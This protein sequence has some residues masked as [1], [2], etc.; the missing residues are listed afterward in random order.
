M[1]E[2]NK[3]HNN[4]NDKIIFL[5]NASIHHSK[6]FK[7]YVKET[8]MHVLYNVPYDKNPVEYVFSLLRKVLERSEFTT[9]N[10]LTKIVNNFKNNL[11]S[12]KLNNIFRH[13]FNLF[14]LN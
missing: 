8:K 3:I 4:E 12:N 2:F 10:E 5:D 6:D 14:N 9:I 11:I 13:S 7:Q 1:T